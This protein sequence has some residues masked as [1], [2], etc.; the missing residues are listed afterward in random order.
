MAE[1]VERS[2]P[3]LGM[4]ERLRFHMSK[5][6]KAT[7]RRQH[8]VRPHT[9]GSNY[10]LNLIDNDLPPPQHFNSGGVNLLVQPIQQYRMVERVEHVLDAV[11]KIAL[12]TAFTIWVVAV[13]YEKVAP[14][15]RPAIDY[16]FMR[17]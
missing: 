8:Q 10:D 7:K 17:G 13:A 16:V 4:A 12:K 9:S 1:G 15:I 11:E 6:N 2:P 14:Y 5:R 3:S